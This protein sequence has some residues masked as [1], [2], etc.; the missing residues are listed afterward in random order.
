[1]TLDLIFVII[2]AL[3]FYGSIALL[4]W[5]SRRRP[6]AGS[7]TEGKPDEKKNQK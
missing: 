4:V 7:A 3:L 6:S 2:L 5:R 1:M